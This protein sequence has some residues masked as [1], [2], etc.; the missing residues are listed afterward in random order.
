M[1]FTVCTKL[2]GDVPVMAIVHKDLL[3]DS[4]SIHYKV[5]ST[6]K[7][8]PLTKTV[9]SVKAPILINNTTLTVQGSKVPTANPDKIA[10]WT[11]SST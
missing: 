4:G 5:T 1:I 7:D 8:V 9:T 2:G 6:S 11:L 10:R 3:V